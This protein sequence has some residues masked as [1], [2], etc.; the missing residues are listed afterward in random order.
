VRVF[1]YNIQVTKA[2]VG[3]TLPPS[4]W[5]QVNSG[6]GW[7]NIIREGF[8]GAWQQNVEIRFDSVV[9][10]STVYACAT[11]IASDI[12]KLCLNLVSENEDT[13]VWDDV[14]S[15]AF[16]PILIKPN[17]YQIRQKFIEQWVT[18]KLLHGNAY[19]LKERDNRNVVT[20]MYV[21]DPLLTR[22]L[23]AP[24]GSIYYQLST[25][26]LAGIQTSAGGVDTTEVTRGAVVVPASEI[27]HDV[28]VPLYHPLLGVSPITACGLAATQGLNIQNN[29]TVFFQNGSRPSGI[30]TAP[31]VI[32][33]DTAKRLKEHWEQNYT[34]VNSGKVA[35]LGDGLKYEGMT[36]NAVDSALI[37]QLKWTSE[38]VCSVFH[39]PPYMVG[40]S[41]PPKYNN[42]E[43]LNSQYYS[44]CLQTLMEA[45]EG[46]L[47]DGLGLGA[48][49]YGT[50]FDLSDLLK[51][52]TATQY[53]TYGD[54][55]K[56]GILAPNEARQKLNLPPKA[57]GESPYL[58]QQNYSLAALAKR[59]AKPDPF[60]SAKP[61]APATPPGQLPAPGTKPQP[62][63]APPQKLLPDLRLDEAAIFAEMS[64]GADDHASR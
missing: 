47:D 33:D 6:A 10:F 21:L 4:G 55:V 18:S 58:Q 8:P 17:H 12:G 49:G 61:P 60:A 39:V 45:I 9:T 63:P 16:S 51:M 34:G 64:L 54:G 44:Q 40:A 7:T 2:P 25:N 30:L 53:K 3:P 29:S 32:S 57:G 22:V 41:P 52:D 62:A 38:T 20:R 28:M 15:P 13:E 36:V 19:V 43:A 35:V 23:I 42:V 31:G 59:D 27:I 11:L 14:D 37:D 48:L 26:W 24:D 50:E 56:N 46:L 5:G 1:G